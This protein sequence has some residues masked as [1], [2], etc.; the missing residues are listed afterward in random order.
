VPTTDVGEDD[1][2][3]DPVVESPS[4]KRHRLES[5]SQ[6]NVR[7]VSNRLHA[8]EQL[9]TVS[10]MFVEINRISLFG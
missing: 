6:S 1:G 4:N 7:Q 3:I 2:M 8:K 10:A 5:V 9:V